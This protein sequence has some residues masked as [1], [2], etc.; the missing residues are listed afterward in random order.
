MSVPSRPLFASAIITSLKTKQ[1][2][3]RIARKGASKRLVKSVFGIGM[4]GTR[5]RYNRAVS[6]PR[7]AFCKLVPKDSIALLHNRSREPKPC[8]GFPYLEGLLIWLKRPKK[9]PPRCACSRLWWIPRGEWMRPVRLLNAPAYLCLRVLQNKNSDYLAN[10]RTYLAYIR[11][12]FS[13]IAFGFVIARFVLFT[14][15]ISRIAHI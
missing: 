15:E 9:R 10:E 12:A 2:R 7:V 11:T 3:R 14:H 6:Y 5:K 4:T 1:Y 13:F 8:S